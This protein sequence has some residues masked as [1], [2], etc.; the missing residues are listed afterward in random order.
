[1]QRV[2]IMVTVPLREKCLMVQKFITIT[3]SQRT[4]KAVI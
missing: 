1:M 2:M 3:A 4:A